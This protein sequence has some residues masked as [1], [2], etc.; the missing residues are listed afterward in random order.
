MVRF[1]CASVTMNCSAE[2]LNIRA[3]CP[4]LQSKCRSRASQ[5]TP[6]SAGNAA[7][8]VGTVPRFVWMTQRLSMVV[9]VSLKNK[10]PEQS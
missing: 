2:L 6:E 4:A 5:F 1:A 9:G 7:A 3:L 8:V 10:L